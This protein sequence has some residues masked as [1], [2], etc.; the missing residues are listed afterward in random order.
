[1]TKCDCAWCGNY[2]EVYAYQESTFEEDETKEPFIS[3]D[4]A[5]LKDGDL[6]GLPICEECYKFHFDCLGLKDKKKGGEK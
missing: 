6:I 2:R 4:K 1:M 5:K 3:A